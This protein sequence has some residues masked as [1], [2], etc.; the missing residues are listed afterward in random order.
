MGAMG[1]LAMLVLPGCIFTLEDQGSQWDQ[2]PVVD[3]RGRDG[4]E[5]PTP[6]PE[7]DPIVVLGQESIE[8]GST[9]IVSAFLEDR[10]ASEAVDIELFGH[11]ELL[12]WQEMADDELGLVIQV[13]EHAEGS[14]D[15]LFHFDDGAA[16]FLE[17]ALE[18][19]AAVDPP[20]EGGDDTACP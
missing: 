19:Q 6:E 2:P 8:A 12:T 15:L 18:I 20:M 14:I 13:P 17:G 5:D 3:D 16:S 10:W 9:A 4:E 7:P 1:I 11:A